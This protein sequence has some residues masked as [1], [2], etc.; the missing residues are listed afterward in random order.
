MRRVEGCIGV[1]DD[2]PSS[3]RTD[4]QRTY[5]YPEWGVTLQMMDFAGVKMRK[6]AFA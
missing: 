5:N 3:R 6:N 2:V 4:M 1:G